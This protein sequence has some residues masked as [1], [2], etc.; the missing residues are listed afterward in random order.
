[1]NRLEVNIHDD[2][3]A[4]LRIVMGLLG[5]NSATES[6]AAAF[7]IARAILEKEAQGYKIQARKSKWYW[8][9]EFITTFKFLSL[10]KKHLKGA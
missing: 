6:T 2:T 10:W 3:T 9:T 4:N 5:T 8:D 7:S 1:M